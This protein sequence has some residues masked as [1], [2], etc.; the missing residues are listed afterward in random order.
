MIF[1]INFMYEMLNYNLSFSWFVLLL[2]C[3]FEDVRIGLVKVCLWILILNFIVFLGVIWIIIFIYILYV[4]Y[5]NW[6][7]VG[8]GVLVMENMCSN[9]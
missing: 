4:D 3:Y 9:W 7:M 2:W 6:N 8:C 1:N 5:V